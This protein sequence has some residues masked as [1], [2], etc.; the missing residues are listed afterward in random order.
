MHRLSLAAILATALGICVLGC[1]PNNSN[2]N[3]DA[4]PDGG[5]SGGTRRCDNGRDECL[6]GEACNTTTGECFEVPSCARGD[7]SCTSA[8]P[9]CDPNAPTAC[10]ACTADSQ[11]SGAFS[12]CSAQS[13]DEC[14]Q[15]LTH[16]D[17][18]SCAT[19]MPAK[20]VIP[21]V[22][23]LC[24]S[25]PRRPRS[26]RPARN[27]ASGSIAPITSRFLVPFVSETCRQLSCHEPGFQ[28]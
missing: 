17:C 23:R 1:T 26:S 24:A 8:V 28:K 13:P 5:P 27:C 12:K 25:P 18:P 6:A 19:A 21:R 16:A 15:C 7:L 4:G 3:P 11:C 14:V 2:T 20:H 22:V 9:S 10:E